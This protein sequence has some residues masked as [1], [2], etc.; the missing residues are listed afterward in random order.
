M[1]AYIGTGEIDQLKNED[2]NIDMIFI[3]CLAPA[4]GSQADTHLSE[5]RAWLSA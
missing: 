4:S 2:R 3:T 1:R 5:P